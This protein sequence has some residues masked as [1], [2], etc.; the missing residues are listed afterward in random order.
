MYESFSFNREHVCT[1]IKIYVNG[2]IAL[3]S[4]SLP[5][6]TV[7]TH[8]L[9]VSGFFWF[10]LTTALIGFFSENSIQNFLSSHA[11]LF[12]LLSEAFAQQEIWKRTKR[13]YLYFVICFRCGCVTL[14]YRT[15]YVYSNLIQTQMKQQVQCKSNNM[16]W[17][18]MNYVVHAVFVS[19]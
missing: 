6:I 5:Q 1:W 19:C 7:M 11:D 8:D 9:R 17:K 3:A 14:N 16:F 2:C 13:N 15:W 18:L 12:I 10:L 4:W